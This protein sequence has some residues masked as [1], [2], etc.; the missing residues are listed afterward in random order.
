MLP[1]S[2]RLRSRSDFASVL[3]GPGGARTGNRLLVVH[4]R[5]NAARTG[6]P[7]RVGFV[8]SRA[9]GGA[10]VRNRVKRRLRAACSIA[11]GNIPEA[12]DVVV[13]AN[14][15]SAQATFAELSEAFNTLVDKGIRRMA[16]RP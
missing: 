9:V 2:S 15:P 5:R 7:P 3:R 16:A 10:V 11:L 6:M 1:A 14:P 12:T 13:R 4:L 8:V